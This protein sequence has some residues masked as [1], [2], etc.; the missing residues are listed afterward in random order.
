MINTYKTISYIEASTQLDEA[1]DWLVNIGIK[2]SN[3]RIGKYKKIFNALSEAQNNDKLDKYIKSICI[4]DFT[5]AI[6]E[7][8]EI[9]KIHKGLCL[10]KDKQL[11]ERIK[12]SSKSHELYIKDISDRS[13]RDFA[14]ELTIA[15]KFALQNYFI[16]YNHKADLYVKFNNEYLFVECKRLKSKKQVEKNIKKGLKQLLE[17]YKSSEKPESS[18][19][20][21]ILSIAKLYNGNLGILEAKDSDE[22]GAK[23]FAYNQKFV[24]Q[25]NKLWHYPNSGDGRTLGVFIVFSS[26]GAIKKHNNS[27][28]TYTTFNEIAM[29]NA[30]SMSTNSYQLLLEIAS[31]VFGNE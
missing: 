10:I 14:F 28:V 17:R 16:D 8:S 29:N 2:V 11:Y 15:A 30:V 4:Y 7:V 3:T 26:I 24:E 22:L 23:A 25:Y 21:L 27:K 6:F 12:K 5:N 19:G 1:C 31:T 13:G 9:I 20:I 18:Y